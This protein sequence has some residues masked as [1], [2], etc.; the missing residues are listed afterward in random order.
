MK[1]LMLAILVASVMSAGAS[2]MTLQPYECGYGAAFCGPIP[3][4][5]GA[6]VYIYTPNARNTVWTELN[7]VSY[8][9]ALGGTGFLLS[10]QNEVLPETGGTGTVTLTA[11]FQVVGIRRAG[12][13]IAYD[14]EFLCGSL[15]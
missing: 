6:V 10:Y 1:K 4:D 2:A 11:S 5:A 3:N 14:Y 7:G 12:R 9:K 8:D 13:A 15:N